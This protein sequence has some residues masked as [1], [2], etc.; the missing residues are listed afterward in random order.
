M[1]SS[2]WGLQNILSKALKSRG[3]W[4]AAAR[5]RAHCAPRGGS[6]DQASEPWEYGDGRAPDNVT[7]SLGIAGKTVAHMGE[8]AALSHKN[9]TERRSV[10]SDL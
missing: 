5:T 4:K 9:G 2:R 3:G 10:V 1:G 6:S 8:G 7:A